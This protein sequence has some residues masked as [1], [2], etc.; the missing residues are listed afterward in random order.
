MLPVK[1]DETPD[2]LYM[3]KTMKTQEIIVL[4]KYCD[5]T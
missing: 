5:I 2:Y 1:E 4:K 3:E